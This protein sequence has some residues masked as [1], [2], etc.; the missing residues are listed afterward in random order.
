M[1]LARTSKSELSQWSNE[2][3]A[4]HNLDPFSRGSFLDKCGAAMIPLLWQQL[5]QLQRCIY[6]DQHRGR[7]HFYLHP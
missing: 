3:I 4:P 1:T 2:T 6:V 7:V 5:D